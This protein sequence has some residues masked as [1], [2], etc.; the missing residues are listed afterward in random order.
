MTTVRENI[1]VPFHKAIQHAFAI[2]TGT[3]QRF[4]LVSGLICVDWARHKSAMS[5]MAVFIIYLVNILQPP[6][7]G[8]LFRKKTARTAWTNKYLKRYKTSTKK[9]LRWSTANGECT[10]Q[11]WIKWRLFAENKFLLVICGDLRR[12][13]QMVLI[14]W[15]YY[16]LSSNSKMY[17]VPSA[18]L[19]LLTTNA[20][21]DSCSCRYQKAL[22]PCR[23]RRMNAIHSKVTTAFIRIRKNIGPERLNHQQK[24]PHNI[25]WATMKG[26]RFLLKKHKMS[27]HRHRKND[28]ILR[29]VSKKCGLEKFSGS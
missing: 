6:G 10:M 21:A 9:L 25:L 28:R 5:H 20:V 13:Q 29:E 2:M 4:R 23:M 18:F 12:C 22:G 7:R 1:K 27:M 15:W 19:W 3:S 14:E 8:H 11:H 24:R 16:S 17:H 26:L